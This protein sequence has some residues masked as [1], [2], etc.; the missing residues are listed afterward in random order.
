MKLSEIITYKNLLESLT[1]LDSMPVAHDILSPVLKTVENNN[2]QFDHLTRQLQQNYRYVV[3]TLNDFEDTLENIKQSLQELI[4]Q[5]EHSYYRESTELYN[6]DSGND[7]NEYILSRKLP[8]F[9]EVVGQLIN[10]IQA[11]NNWHHAGMIIRP[12][13]EDWINYLV[14][15]DPMYLMDMSYEL[16]EPAVLRFNDQYR[17]RLRT[18][19]LQETLDGTMFDKIPNKQ[20][21]ICLI[22][23]FFN[24][25]PIEVIESYLKELYNKLKPGGTIA[26]TFNDCDRAAGVELAERYF[27]SYTPARAMLDMAKKLGYVVAY[28]FRTG[29]SNTW[30]ELQR[31]GELTSIKGGQSL[32][33][34]LYK[35]EYFHY[36]KEQI[37]NIKQQAADL[38][39]ARSDELDQMPI[40][41]IVTLLNQ[42]T[43]K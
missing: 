32:A 41:Q 34:I 20:L 3:K 17:R 19:V 42:R 43:S 16:L 7:T 39:I 28:N 10:R 30:L 6:N 8:I 21:G 40:G 11:H 1:P 2:V 14:G 18:Y 12:G 33:K 4:E 9:D 27:M 23:N 26:M 25:K 13:H 38:N 29:A 24:Y 35:D 22:W 15:C 36:T 37:K 5:S 31:P